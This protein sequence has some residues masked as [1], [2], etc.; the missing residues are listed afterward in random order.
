[1]KFRLL[2]ISVILNFGLISCTTFGTV[3]EDGSIET[4]VD[5][6]LEPIEDANPPAFIGVKSHNL[7]VLVY[8]QV[9]NQA[10]FDEVSQTITGVPEIRKVFN[11]LRIADPEAVSDMND[12]WITTKLRSSLVAEKGLDSKRIT[13]LTENGEVFL[14]GLVTRAEADKAT[15]IARNISGVTK[16]VKIFEYID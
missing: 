2:L 12:S 1:M 15:L 7:Y 11:E 13:V 14:M 8:G 16:V 4:R 6:L 3:A 5:D 9:P 10:V